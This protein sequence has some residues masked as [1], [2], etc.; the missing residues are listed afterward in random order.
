M[1]NEFLIKKGFTEDFFTA[2]WFLVD[3]H[4]YVFFYDLIM[5]M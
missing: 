3:T 2:Y 4:I 5:M 1:M